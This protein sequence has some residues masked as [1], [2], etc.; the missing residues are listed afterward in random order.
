MQCIH[1]V[2][3][4]TFNILSLSVHFN[5]SD[6]ISTNPV[7]NGG[8]QVELGDPQSKGTDKR[9]QVVKEE[10]EEEEEEEK[11]LT[12][13]PE[14]VP[15][16]LAPLQLPQLRTKNTDSFDMEEVRSTLHSELID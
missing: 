13:T 5:S 8:H 10:T 9:I 6:Q 3:N 1:V 11:K 14:R 2:L 12:S 15:P 7:I 16:T 4:R